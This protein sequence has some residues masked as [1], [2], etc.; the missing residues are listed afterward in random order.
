MKILLFDLG[1]N[2]EEYNEPIGI[3]CLQPMLLQHDVD[4]YWEKI[5][6]PPTYKKYDL[7]GLS[8]GLGRYDYFKKQMD[9]IKTE[10]PSAMVFVGGNTPT[11][12]YE[13]LLAD[14]PEIVCVVG[15]GESATANLVEAF[16]NKKITL[17]EIKNLAFIENGS[18]VETER[19]QEDLTLHKGAARY[20]ISDVIDRQGIA[21]IEGSRGCP[22]G[23]CSFCCVEAKYG[24]STWRPFPIDHILIELIKLNDLGITSPYFTDEDF[25]GEDYPRSIKL[26]QL[27]VEQKK[28]GIIANEMNFFAS[29]RVKDVNKEGIVALKEWKKAG[30]REVFIGVES[31]SEE[32][33]KRY[34]K[35][36]LPNENLK[37]IETLQ[38]LGF[39]VDTGFILFDPQMNYEELKASVKLIE[40][41]H[42]MGID[43]R[44]IKSLRVQPKTKYYFDIIAK[45]TTT[46][47][48]SISSLKYDI[49]Y[50]DKKVLKAKKI[51]E[52]FDSIFKEELH[53]LQAKS[54]GEVNSEDERA[55]IKKTL[56]SCRKVDTQ[57]LSYLI[58]NLDSGN[59]KKYLVSF[60]SKKE[61]LLKNSGSDLNPE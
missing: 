40:H 60:I 57:A 23:K 14:F 33:L 9:I 48:L 36:V 43:S 47:P 27:I 55:T 4:M 25:F 19:L 8:V 56:D 1:T 10:N 44:S 37:A 26:A 18:L 38:N 17:K 45:G 51:F 7:I 15:E 41:I 6:T 13:E 59:L 2:R 46:S 24:S 32:Q 42:D 49:E 34:K 11:F 54:R 3:C 31:C 50:Q 53:T 21:R 29:I 5:S 52:Q 20:F 30:L 39:T 61:A 12:A 35:G 22:W 58:K 16:E 28:A